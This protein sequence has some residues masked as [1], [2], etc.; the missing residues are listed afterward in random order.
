VCRLTVSAYLW[1]GAVERHADPDD[2]RVKALVLTPEGE[3]LR[4]G[5]WRA[6]TEDPGPLAPLDDADLRALTRI[7]DVLSLPLSLS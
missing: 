4:A 1:R 6:L 2:R 5:F 3:R 7:V